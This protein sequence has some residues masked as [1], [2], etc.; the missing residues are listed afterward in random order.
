MTPNDILDLIQEMFENDGAPEGTIYEKWYAEAEEK[1][2][3]LKLI[4]EFGC[5]VENVELRL[6]ELGVDPDMG[7]KL[8]YNYL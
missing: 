2:Y 7:M 5:F 8:I 3:G 1:L 4:D 6:F